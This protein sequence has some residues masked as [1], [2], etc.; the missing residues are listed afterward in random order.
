VDI[1]SKVPLLIV[2][3]LEASRP[4]KEFEIQVPPMV[5]ANFEAATSSIV[6]DGASPFFWLNKWLP[7]GRLK[8][9][10]PHLFASIPRR[11]S[12]A[13]IVRDCLD[14]GWL[15]D[16]PT[17]LGALTIEELLAV[18]NGVEGLAVTVGVPNVLWWN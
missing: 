4:W 14:G 1:W 10:A 15:D 5:M 13:R 17:N 9:L 16:I 3:T 11:L 6:G 12:R 7:D 2:A 8:D 18:A